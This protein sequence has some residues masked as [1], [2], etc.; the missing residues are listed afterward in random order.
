M[1]LN[2]GESGY[3]NSDEQTQR[4]LDVDWISKKLS[5]PFIIPAKHQNHAKQTTSQRGKEKYLPLR[6]ADN[7]LIHIDDPAKDKPPSNQNHAPTTAATRPIPSWLS[8]PG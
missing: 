1:K 6:K 7:N 8:L 5:L 4:V 2:L 3:P